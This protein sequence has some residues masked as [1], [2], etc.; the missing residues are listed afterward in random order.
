MYK[1]VLLSYCSTK[2]VILLLRGSPLS[3]LLLSPCAHRM[4]KSAVGLINTVTDSEHGY[5]G[6]LTPTALWA[7][8]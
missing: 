2:V 1:S 7:T 6:P 3:I 8:E 4:A 5:S